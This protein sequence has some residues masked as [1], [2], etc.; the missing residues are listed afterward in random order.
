MSELV[1]RAQVGE[2]W[3]R[4]ATD[5]RS[6][7]VVES[8]LGPVVLAATGQG[9]GMVSF[10]V[11]DAGSSVTRIDSVYYT[12]PLSP[13]VTGDAALIA[14]G[15]TQYALLAGTTSGD[16]TGYRLRD[17]GRFA[18]QTTLDLPSY[19]G[20]T[21][22]VVAT[23][24][25]GYVYSVTGPGRV[26]G[27]E[28]N[29]NGTYRVIETVTDGIETFAA[30]PVAMQ[31]VTVGGAEFLMVLDGGEIGLT[32]FR[33]DP[34]TGDLTAESA[35][36]VQ[37]GLG[38]LQNPTGLEILSANGSTFVVVASASDQSGGGALSVFELTQS[39][40]LQVTDHVL[41]SRDT[42]FGAVESLET[43][44]VDGW[45]YVL[46][47]GGD[48]G[49][50][51]F[52]LMPNGRLHH[53]DTFVDTV[54]AGL[55]RISALSVVQDGDTLHVF[56][57]S[58]SSEGVAHL[59][60]DLSDQGQV[61]ERSSG[62][63]QG[64]TESD[65]LVGGAGDNDLRGEAGDDILVDGRGTDRM[66]GGLG[67]DTFVLEADG[68]R[69][70]ITDF[71]PGQ[72]RLDLSS[73]PMLYDAS[74]LQVIEQPWGAVLIFPGGE[75]TEIRS[76]LGQRL[77]EQ[78]VLSAIDWSTDRP[79][80][81]IFNEISGSTQRDDL[82]GSAGIDIIRGMDGNDVLRGFDGDDRLNGGAGGDTIF[83]GAG[84]D[85]INGERGPDSI[86]A[87]TGD[88][89]IVDRPQGGALGQDTIWAGAGNDSVSSGGGADLVYGEDG[90][91]WVFAG[92]G[93]DTLT[94]A[95]G[96]DTLMGA[97]GFDRILGQNGNDLLEGGMGNDQLF[98]GPGN[99]TL[100]GGSN[101]DRL[102]GNQGNDTLEGMHGIDRLDGGLGNDWMHGGT[103]ADTLLGGPGNDTLL[104]ALGDDSLEGQNGRDLIEGGDGNDW[105]H[106]GAMGDTVLG[107]DGNDTI[108]GGAGP[109]RIEMGA[110]NDLFQGYYQNDALGRDTIF[111]GDGNDTV[112]ASAG[113]DVAHGDVGNDSLFGGL[114]ND[115]LIGGNGRDTLEGWGGRDTLEGGAHQDRLE[116]GNGNDLLTGGSGADTFVFNSA[117]GRDVITDF[118][119]GVDQLELDVAERTFQDLT[120]YNA[121][122]GVRL[123]WEG[124]SL[125]LEGLSASDI[126]AS[127]VTF[128]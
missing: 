31:T 65:L 34:A 68:A 82:S 44:E 79:P 66:T 105:I 123:E 48:A 55:E 20:P 5:I 25:A 120:V 72:D 9:G 37:T 42:R 104:G 4:L 28:Q 39:G 96:N 103:E 63:I 75:Q 110:G 36:G 30:A 2:N 80:L 112:Q 69:D 21:G 52:L 11:N 124:G 73:V 24:A 117:S 115:S 125:L 32:A 99:D 67:A 6:M 51:L 58:Q 126:G 127:D 41:D 3:G 119:P 77:S 62:L 92:W 84:S 85:E 17:D 121:P 50:S 71:R 33:I 113:D 49:I 40:A 94:G 97:G 83:G 26:Q 88:D 57:A 128:V 108:N 98:G 116:G 19:D 45:T 16:T 35:V 22:P 1:W 56:A 29:A 76:A 81:V 107:G 102:F 14:Q 8:A 95:A 89:V 74:R 87:G 61:I 27:F 70:V 13:Y 53:L 54:E 93:N 122:R 38:L 23:S 101:A 91:D 46:A 43:V 59:T 111:G 18:T 60:I 10:R 15:G 100:Q 106:G 12:S 118:T 64:E 47:G 114:G 78:Q 7:Q 86:V 109:D 90:H